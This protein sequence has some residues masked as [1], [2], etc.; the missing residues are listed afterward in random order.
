MYLARKKGLLFFN[1]EETGDVSIQRERKMYRERLKGRG[2]RDGRSE[3][4]AGRGGRQRGEGEGPS[5]GRGSGWEP[6]NWWKVL[7]SLF[8]L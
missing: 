1:M 5:G 4:A 2:L 6:V 3:E 8:S 7:A